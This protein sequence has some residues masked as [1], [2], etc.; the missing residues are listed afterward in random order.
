LPADPQLAPGV[1]VTLQ[2]AGLTP[3]VSYA[4]TEHSVV[5]SLGSVIVAPD[6]SAQLNFV[7]TA[8]VGYG[9]HEVDL[10]DSSGTTVTSFSFTLI[11]Q[12]LAF[13][14]SPDL[15]LTFISLGLLLIGISVTMSANWRGFLLRGWHV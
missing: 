7:T 13:T 9:A 12:G 3:G 2:F 14:G 5:V 4:A 6:G 1:A 15:G 11:Q 10:T 8:N